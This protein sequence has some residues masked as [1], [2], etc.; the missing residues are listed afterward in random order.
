[1]GAPVRSRQK[2][3]FSARRSP[4]RGTPR[5]LVGSKGAITVHSK[6]LKSNRAIQHLQAEELH[7]ASR[8]V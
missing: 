6:S 8:R 7:Q 3:P 2:M 4:T 1:M 5:G